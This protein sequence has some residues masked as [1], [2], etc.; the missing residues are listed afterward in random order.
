LELNEININLKSTSNKNEIEEL[1]KIFLKKESSKDKIIERL[2]SNLEEKNKQI[3]NII[4]TS[5][6][7]TTNN[8]GNTT[9][10]TSNTNNGKIDLIIF[11]YLKNYN[12]LNSQRL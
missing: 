4:K 11:D 3:E 6:P 7:K 5:K 10:N 1:K 2:I 8:I 12:F 9:N